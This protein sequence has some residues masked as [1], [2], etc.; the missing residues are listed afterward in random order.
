LCI[1]LRE[2]RNFD[3]EE[4]NSMSR[5]QGFTL[6]ELL[7]VIAIIALLMSILMPALARVRR[8]AKAVLCQSNLKQFGACYAMY[9]DDYEGKFLQGWR[10][11]GSPG[12][13]VFHTDY[14]MEGLRK[15]YKDA[16]LRLCPM[17][18]IPGSKL[19]KGTGGGAFYAWG[20]FEVATECGEPSTWPAVTAC[21]Y[22]SYGFSE[23]ICDP[24]P[25]VIIIQTHETKNNWRTAEV[26]GAGFIGIHGDQQW[27]DAWPD[28]KPPPLF[29]GQPWGVDHENSMLRICINRHNR[30]V[31]WVFMDYS[32]RKLGLKQLWRVKWHRRYDLQVEVD[33]TIGTGWLRSYKDYY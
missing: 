28:G 25:G 17:A 26:K 20:I 2:Q 6:V 1:L 19:G 5:Q 3:R 8:Q 33:W 30:Y 22:G 32:V 7:V 15:Y 31:N 27:I 24:P 18:N 13:P 12:P 10:G 21:D 16:N 23:W 29:E 11:G 9:T 4:Y 14:W